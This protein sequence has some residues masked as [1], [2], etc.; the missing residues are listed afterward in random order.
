MSDLDS[1]LWTVGGV[2][3]TATTCWGAVTHLF[4]SPTRAAERANS[5][6]DKSRCAHVNMMSANPYVLSLPLLLCVSSSVE[7]KHSVTHEP[8]PVQCSAQATY[9]ENVGWETVGIEVGWAPKSPRADLWSYIRTDTEVPVRGRVLVVAWPH[10]SSPVP[11]VAE[12]RTSP[13]SSPR[14]QM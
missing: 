3:A 7:R 9:V 1:S 13:A 6:N 12:P 14:F 5:N 2:I 10:L 11:E 4:S 8:R